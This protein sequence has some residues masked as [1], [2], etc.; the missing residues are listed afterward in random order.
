MLDHSRTDISDRSS[1]PLVTPAAALLALAILG[2][3]ACASTGHNATRADSSQMTN[4]GATVDTTR[5]DTHHKG[6]LKLEDTAAEA[7]SRDGT[8]DA[9]T[10]TKMES[11]GDAIA[12]R[13]I[14]SAEDIGR[15]YFG[16]DS[17]ALDADD[18]RALDQA[19]TWLKAHPTRGLV[20]VGHADR[21][22][23]RGYNMQLALDRAR[24]A[25]TYIT[26]NGI[27][28]ARIEATAH[29]EEHLAEQTPDYTRD[30]TNRR[31]IMRTDPA[32]AYGV[33]SEGFDPSELIAWMR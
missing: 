8:A 25:K 21:A 7:S 12:S 22:G 14:Y 33:N 29:G 18:R 19:V 4:V 24:A 23:S 32:N 30:A 15:I 9:P 3:T 1:S 31:V 6:S 26:D 10:S 20:L 5:A 27:S 13:Y 11:V 16:F 28:P 17:S 2:L